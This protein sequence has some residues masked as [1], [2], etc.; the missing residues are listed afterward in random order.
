MAKG[1]ADRVTAFLFID[2]NPWLV[3]M[4]DSLLKWLLEIKNFGKSTIYK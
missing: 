4:E 2:I 1:A 3:Q